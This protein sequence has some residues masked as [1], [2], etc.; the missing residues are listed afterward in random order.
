MLDRVLRLDA[1][2]SRL[3]TS[4]LPVF[5]LGNEAWIGPVCSLGASGTTSTGASRT[6]WESAWRRHRS[7]VLNQDSG[8]ASSLP[9][10]TCLE[11]VT[12]ALVAA[13]A[14]LAAFRHLT[15]I[16]TSD[17]CVT[18]VDL[19][20][21]TSTPHRFVPHPLVVPI[22]TSSNKNDFLSGINRL[23]A[24]E[25]VDAERLGRRVMTLIDEHFGVFTEISE[26][27]LAQVPL[28][29]ALASVTSAHLDG[30]PQP[31][32]PIVGA[33]L[34]SR[35]ARSRAAL[36]GL[37][38]YAST[39]LDPRRL[40]GSSKPAVWAYRLADGS[41]QVLDVAIAYQGPATSTGAPG[42]GVAAGHTWEDAL[43]TGLLS[44]CCKL[45]VAEAVG[46]NTV[47]PRINLDGLQLDDEGTAYVRL[48]QLT[49]MELI[50]YDITEGLGVLTLAFCVGKRTV[51]YASGRDFAEA[52]RHGL[53]R[54]LLDYQAQRNG[55]PK[56]G[57][58]DVPQLPR[59]SRGNHYRRLVAKERTS[60]DMEDMLKHLAESGHD[61]L[62][63]PLDHDP[64][65]S[66]IL[67]YI[68]NVVV[69]DA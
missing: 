62:V 55:H 35:T 54:V 61:A 57:L 67:P 60:D 8:R 12:A 65:V 7:Q 24:G 63:V 14:G 40:T 68:V 53:D 34:D 28:S 29:V 33:G 5:V 56:Y 41:A 13:V 3:N 59:H 43:L 10:T 49:G 18:C 50:V 9:P 23:R 6:T 2:C 37:A 48:L 42:S 51:A 66:D 16:D 25:S 4:F 58:S 26:R 19:T 15:G 52:V 1:A 21:L 27:S 47:F 17:E 36:R 22:H 69:R 20:T 45:A 44:Q 30:A 11:G 38:Y 31:P 64:R 39:V 32:H 46:A